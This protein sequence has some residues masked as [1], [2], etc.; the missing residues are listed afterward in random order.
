MG[1]IFLGYL[2]FSYIDFNSELPIISVT[3]NLFALGILFLAL[4]FISSSLMLFMK[5]LAPMGVGLKL[6]SDSL[7]RVLNPKSD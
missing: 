1:L 3:F 2:F 5:D 7:S 6:L 4:D